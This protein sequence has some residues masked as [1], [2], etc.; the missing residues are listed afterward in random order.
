[1]TNEEILE[2][3]SQVTYKPGWKVL[4]G[5]DGE[6]TDNPRAFAQISVDGTTEASL[7]ACARDGTR[8]PWKG[9]KRFFSP[10]MCRQEIVGA[11]F[12]LIQDA[13][14]HEMREWFRYR[15]ASIYNPH[16]DPEAWSPSPAR[17]PTSTSAKTP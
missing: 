17:R 11:C 12:G 3:I 2:I 1:M 13:E 7:D 6:D 8:T 9:S 4:F 10:Y 14:S 15:G 5:I 16:L